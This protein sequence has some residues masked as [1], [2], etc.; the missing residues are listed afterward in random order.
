MKTVLMLIE[1]IKFMVL[2]WAAY[3]RA[4]DS[5]RPVYIASARNGIPTVAIFVGVD[6]S[7]WDIS[8][9]AIEHFR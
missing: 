9:L 3:K 7:A 8:Q 2:A 6:R 4:R 5:R 1:A